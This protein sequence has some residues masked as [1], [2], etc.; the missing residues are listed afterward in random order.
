MVSDTGEPPFDFE[1][2]QD[3]HFI[4]PKVGGRISVYWPLEHQYFP[5][6]VH[7]ISQDGQLV[8]LYDDEVAEPWDLQKEHW[9]FSSAASIVNTH[10]SGF[11]LSL[12]SN[13]QDVLS[14]M[15][16]ALGNRPFLQH[17]AQAFEQ[18]PLVIAYRREEEKYLMNAKTVP[19]S[20]EPKLAS[21]I[22]S[23][24]TSKLKLKD[25][26]SLK[27]KACIAAH[28]SEDWDKDLLVSGCNMRPPIG[29]RAICSTATA[30]KWRLVCVDADATCLQ[31]GPADCKVYVIP[32]RE[33]L[34][35][36][37]LHWPRANCNT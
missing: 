26:Q 35:R 4:L 14:E 11:T 30:R 33:S 8:V 18:S 32:P 12:Q 34:H 16:I 2:G 15:Y 3:Q 13:V 37:V 22:G 1:T 5:G 36:T 31:T 23:H 21:I 6:A 17:Q 27:S 19:R 29:L 20:G 28:G 9:Q 25:Y 7:A 24:T 10:P